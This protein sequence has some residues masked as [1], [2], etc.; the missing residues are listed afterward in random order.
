[1][2]WFPAD[3]PIITNFSVNGSSL[4]TVKETEAVLFTCMAEGNPPPRVSVLNKDRQ[5]IYELVG[6]THVFKITHS[7]CSHFGE[8]T[9]TASN[10][11]G[12]AMGND[13]CATLVVKCK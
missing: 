12:V 8:Y 2:L 3:A 1:M 5:R 9:C 11:E 13:S 4:A 6:N 10:T 7:N